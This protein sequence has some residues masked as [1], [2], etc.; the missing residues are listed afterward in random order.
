MLFLDINYFKD[1]IRSLPPAESADLRTKTW[2]FLEAQKKAGTLKEIY[3]FAD[4]NGAVSIWD[5]S[6]AEDLYLAIQASP[7]RAYL[8]TETIPLL[9]WE[10]LSNIR[11]QRESARKPAKK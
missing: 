7:S 3:W 6:S 5:V 1:S 2:S 11:K 10:G 9:D 4:G 8:E